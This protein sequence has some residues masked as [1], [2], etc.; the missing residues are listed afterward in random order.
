MWLAGVWPTCSGCPLILIRIN[1]SCFL[2]G[3][4]T[5]C[6]SVLWLGRRV[7]PECACIVLFQ[8]LA[9]LSESTH[10]FF[11]AWCERLLQPRA[12]CPC[13]WTM[14]R[15]HCSEENDLRW[16]YGDGVTHAGAARHLWS[17]PRPACYCSFLVDS[18]LSRFYWFCCCSSHF[19]MWKS[20]LDLQD[21]SC[22]TVD[23]FESFIVIC[24]AAID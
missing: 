15:L 18:T 5:F 9:C 19:L 24:D 20:F 6:P 16:I 11:K 23:V 13:V 8:P 21:S 2:G 3:G 22:E 7:C 12:Q 17:Q 14:Q 10:A 1:G 4:F